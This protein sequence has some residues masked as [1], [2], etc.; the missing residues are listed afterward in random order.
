M[1]RN[2]YSEETSK[3]PKAALLSSEGWKQLMALIP[4]MEILANMC[5]IAMGE[6]GNSNKKPADGNQIKA[7][8]LVFKLNNRFTDKNQTVTLKQKRKQILDIT[9][10]DED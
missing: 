1:R 7:A 8:K 10:Q 3:K 2:G 6:K 5:R 9:N 4:E